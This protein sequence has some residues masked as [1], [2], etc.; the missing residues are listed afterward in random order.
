MRE[1]RRQRQRR[2]RRRARPMASEPIISLRGVTK[3][4]RQR[5]DRVPGA[6]GRRSR[7]RSAAISSRSWAPSGSGKSTTMNI[8]G[9]LDVPTAGTFRFKGVPGRDA[10]TATSARCCAA[11]IS[12]SS[13]RAS[14]CSPAP[15]RWRMSSCRC[16]IAART[17]RRG[18]RRRWRRSTR[19]GSADWWDHT[20]AE[21]SRRPAAARRHR[22]RD[23]HQSRRAARRRADRQSRQRDARSRSWNC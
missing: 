2:R 7:R 23:R 6:E 16:S 22:P 17:R 18:A 20:P 10:S 19:S 3:T 13:S 21:L 14:T 1:R 9:C 11:A 8:L 4:Y 5:R 12:A 15:T